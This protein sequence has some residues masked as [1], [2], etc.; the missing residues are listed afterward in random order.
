MRIMMATP[1]ISPCIGEDERTPR[2]HLDAVDVHR[3]G[4]RPTNLTFI[5]IAALDVRRLTS[6]NNFESSVITCPFLKREYTCELTGLTP[7]VTR[8]S[9]G[10]TCNFTTHMA[11][12]RLV[13]ELTKGTPG[14]SVLPVHSHECTFHFNFR[15]NAA[16]SMNRQHG[17]SGGTPGQLTEWSDWSHMGGEITSEFR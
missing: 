5:F 14:G 15:H 17:V 1:F 2:Q 16:S 7:P 12:V 8:S 6:F 10:V 3:P 4:V 11:P 13:R 9:P